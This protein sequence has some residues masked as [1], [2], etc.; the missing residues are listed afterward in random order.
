MKPVNIMAGIG[1]LSLTLLGCEQTRTQDYYMN[2]P[3][4]LAQDLEAC[5]AHQLSPYNCN[6]AD[7]AD[8]YLKHH[9]PAPQ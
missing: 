2:H 3:Q 9:I 8:Y 5:R 4:E 7:K 6:E 1:L